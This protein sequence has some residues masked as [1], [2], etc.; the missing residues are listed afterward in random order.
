LAKIAAYRKSNNVGV[1]LTIKKLKKQANP[2]P[3]KQIEI[4][5]AFNLD[6]IGSVLERK[7]LK[8]KTNSIKN[9][10]NCL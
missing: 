4:D 9:S 5:S 8:K 7:I 3:I 1:P 10:S 6:S 2:K